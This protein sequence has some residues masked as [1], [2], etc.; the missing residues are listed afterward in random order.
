M[1]VEQE[2]MLREMGVTAVQVRII[3]VRKV[4]RK[5]AVP[6][7][8]YVSASLAGGPICDSSTYTTYT[9]SCEKDGT[10]VLEETALLTPLTSL[11]QT[12]VLKL[13]DKRITRIVGSDKLIASMSIPLA[14]T[15]LVGRKTE[16]VSWATLRSDAMY[17][18]TG[19]V[20][21]GIK[22]V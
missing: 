14:E 20:E 8:V 22:L 2:S 11:G 3:R 19:E 1:N 12:I 9:R 18:N 17:S 5:S 6:D 21:V 13:F 16:V 10:A 15:S 7:S 4:T